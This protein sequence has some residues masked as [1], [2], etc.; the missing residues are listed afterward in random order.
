[1]SNICHNNNNKSIFLHIFL[2]IS[3]GYYE[4]MLDTFKPCVGMYNNLMWNTYHNRNGE[5]PITHQS[6]ILYL[7][8]HKKNI[9]CQWFFYYSLTNIEMFFTIYIFGLDTTFFPYQP[10][11]RYH[12]HYYLFRCH[13]S[14]VT[15]VV[16]AKPTTRRQ[17][18]RLL[19]KDFS[20]LHKS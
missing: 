8:I 5:T 18:L 9:L 16:T 6:L 13:C 1:V 11:H 3:K 19:I 12:Y 2:V 20:G 10:P 14:Y 4:Y 15:I 17:K 7:F